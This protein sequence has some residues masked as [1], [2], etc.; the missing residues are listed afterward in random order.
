[1]LQKYPPINWALLIFKFQILF[2]YMLQPWTV[3]SSGDFTFWTFWTSLIF[4]SS[5]VIWC[6]DL[7][8]RLEENA[9]NF[10]EIVNAVENND[11]AGYCSDIYNT[12][13][14]CKPHSYFLSIQTL[15]Q[16]LLFSVEGLLA[17]DQ[18]TQVRRQGRAFHELS[19]SLPTFNPTYKVIAGTPNYDPKFVLK[20]LSYKSI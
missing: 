19:E 20:N 10:Q 4:G 11:L 14:Q 3:S 1:M 12:D 8:F 6:G 15:Q 5:Y 13:R 17:R 16:K 18:L 2:H 9:F 7:N